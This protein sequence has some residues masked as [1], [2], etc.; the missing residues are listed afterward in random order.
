MKPQSG[1]HG[2]AKLPYGQGAIFGVVSYAMGYFITLL[3]VAATEQADNLMK[4]GGWVFYNAQFV[5]VT[6]SSGIRYNL[7][8]GGGDLPQSVVDLP[9]FVYHVVP[10]LMFMG[11]G[12]LLA[13]TVHVHRPKDGVG[14][15]ATL[16]L[17]AVVPAYLGTVMFETSNRAYSASPD[18]VGGIVLV[19]VVFPAISG[20]IGGFLSTQL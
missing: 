5:D 18:L 11:G 7:V 13:R 14:S 8:T 6:V 3:L 20:A 1:Q 19:G 2:L 17:G 10:I 4:L 9:S 12:Y 16:A 15:G